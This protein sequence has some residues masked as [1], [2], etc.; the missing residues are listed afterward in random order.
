MPGLD[1]IVAA[2]E[3]F[4]RQGHEGRICVFMGATAGIGWGTLRRMVT[5]LRNSTFY[6]LGR[7]PSRF[8]AKLAELQALA[9]GSKIIFIQV[10]VSLIS[11]IDAACDE[12]MANEKRVDYVCMSAGGVPFHGAVYTEEKLEACFAVSYY[13][14]L[15]L[16]S[17]LLPL[18]RNSP[19]PRVLS[20]LAGT[21]EKRINEDDIGLEKKWSI[22]G[23]VAHT[24]LCSSLSFDHLAAEESNKL[25]TFIHATPGFVN[26]GTPRTTY[27]SK[28]DGILW[29]AFMSFLQIVSGWYIRY[30]GFSLRESAERHAFYLANNE[31]FPPGSWQT[32]RHNNI[33]PANG[34]L[35]YYQTQGWP[36]RIWD[37]TLKTWE[38]ALAEVR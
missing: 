11:G 1:G 23:V 35:S 3:T 7:S 9:P 31:G 30:F 10:Q 24:T 21:Q 33:V 29:W 6:I 25:I 34:A 20:I 13:S 32:D 36:Q 18:L 22:P 15:R 4:A 2:N 14:R 17:N 26:N 5:M 16:V 27:P 8:A 19:T 28:K 12:I 37:H 38:S